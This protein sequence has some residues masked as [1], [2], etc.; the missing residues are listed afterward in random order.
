MAALNADCLLT[1]PFTVLKLLN[2]V[3]TEALKAVNIVRVWIPFTIKDGV[4][5]NH[6]HIIIPTS[7]FLS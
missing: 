7:T 3:L 2:V 4:K 1:G 5:G 6:P